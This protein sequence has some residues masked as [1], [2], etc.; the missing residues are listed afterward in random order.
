LLCRLEQS[1]GEPQV[2]RYRANCINSNS[3]CGVATSA[4]YSVRTTPTDLSSNGL[5]CSSKSKA[6]W[7]R[8]IQRRAVSPRRIS[9][10]ASFETGRNLA[11][12]G[13]HN[14]SGQVRG[15]ENAFIIMDVRTDRMLLSKW[16]RKFARSAAGL[17]ARKGCDGHC[18]D[19]IYCSRTIRRMGHQSHGS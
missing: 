8:P 2:Q 5:H 12:V 19:Q 11:I 15:M 1:W 3:R 13:M 6:R 4:S 16:L 9:K 7:L 14:A 10:R 18:F 17:L